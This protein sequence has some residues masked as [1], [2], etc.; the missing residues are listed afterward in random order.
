MVFSTS[1]LT[2]RRWSYQDFNNS[3]E[4]WNNLVNQSKVDRLFLSWEWMHTWWQVFSDDSS[5]LMI[6]GVYDE[7]H[8]L[9]GIAPLFAKTVFSKKIVKTRRLQFIGSDWYNN[10]VMR[11]ELLEFIAIPQLSQQVIN[12][13]FDEINKDSQLNEYIFNDLKV[14]SDTYQQ[15][16]KHP[17]FSNH[18]VR[19]IHTV[20][21]YYLN[22]KNS[23]EDYLKKLGK[24]TRLRI[25]N[26]RKNLEQL[27]EVCFQKHS[28]PDIENYLEQLNDFHINRWG[29]KA[30]DN[31]KYCFNKELALLL[32]HKNQL[33]FSSISLNNEIV[34][35]Q[36]NY[37]IAGHKYNIQAGFRTDIH[38]KIALGY[39]HFGYEIEA[40]CDDASINIYDFL[41]G[42]GKNTDY[43]PHLTENYIEL[44]SV[45]IIKGK[46]AQIFYRI[47][48]YLQ[49]LR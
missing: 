10:T 15:L 23:F 42:E 8:C 2:I 43:K 30:F 31:K 13:L 36:Y 1:T 19:P 14:G 26:R 40:A 33:V 49:S 37:N 24:N 6:Y 5:E 46:S 4:A 9:V 29:K 17:L 45:Q 32:N 16:I 3:Q 48:D 12:A 7:S 25:F 47:Y 28:S 38:K 21:S 34:S 27:G 35:V 39:L 11:T 18:Y 22:T 20:K 44:T 41:A